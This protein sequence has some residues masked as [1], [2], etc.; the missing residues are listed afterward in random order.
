MDERTVLVVDDDRAVAQL[1]TDALEGAGFRVTVAH[2]GAAALELD[3]ASPAAVVVLDLMLPRPTGF[4]LLE[5]WRR[6][7][8][9]PILA[10]SAIPRDPT[11]Q[12]RLHRLGVSELMEKPVDPERLVR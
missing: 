10:V 4:D 6:G 2:D 11:A 12:E 7:P 1:W 5:R 8:T 3:E 9:R